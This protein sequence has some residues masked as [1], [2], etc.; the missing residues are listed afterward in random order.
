MTV[1]SIRFEA[2]LRLLTCVPVTGLALIKNVTDEPFHEVTL[3][4]CQHY[5]KAIV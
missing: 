1:Y 3:Y 4:R 5:F 2:C